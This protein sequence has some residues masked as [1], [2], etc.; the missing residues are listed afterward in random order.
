MDGNEDLNDPDYTEDPINP[1]VLTDPLDP[2]EP[3]EPDFVEQIKGRWSPVGFEHNTLY[4]FTDTLRYTIYSVV[5][6]QFGSISDAIPNPH[7]WTVEGDQIV[8][9]LHFGN[10]SRLTPK[11]NANNTLVE[12]NDES[13]K[14]RD[15]WFREG[16]LFS[17]LSVTSNRGGTVKSLNE[18]L[19]S[20]F[21][22]AE[23]SDST[24]ISRNSPVTLTASPN[25]GYIFDGWSG[26]VTG[27]SVD[28][29][30]V[31][32]SDKTLVANFINT[33]VP[34]DF[35]GILLKTGDGSVVIQTA[36]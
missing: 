27:T 12:L 20:L 18:G 6:G 26:D 30:L 22:N 32:D 28:L 2:G 34:E 8:I 7:P 19:V 35:P 33:E 15:T 25:D 24:Y 17:K 4:E 10:Y 11:F 29:S 1:E 14:T 36:D 5:E 21:I 16:H 9:D 23:S 31:L 3:V 13:G